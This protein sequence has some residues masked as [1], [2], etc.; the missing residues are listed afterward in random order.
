MDV[1]QLS[2][3]QREAWIFYFD[4]VFHPCCLASEAWKTL[5]LACCGASAGY[6]ATRASKQQVFLLVRLDRSQLL[7]EE[8]RQK[9]ISSLKQ[10][11]VTLDQPC[12]C[13]PGRGTQSVA[14]PLAR[15][16]LLCCSST[17]VCVASCWTRSQSL[18]PSPAVLSSRL[19][20]AVPGLA[21]QLWE[22][23][24]QCSPT[25]DTWEGVEVVG[26]K[27]RK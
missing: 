9:A 8:R 23:L 14:R 5:E 6:K 21:V 16:C 22:H 11:G 3:C 1:S 12:I 18:S 7:A 26:S 19:I 20:E 10:D 17:A 15:S 13:S 27:R 2:R 25:D 4:T 24:C